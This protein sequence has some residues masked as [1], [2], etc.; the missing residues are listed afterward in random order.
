MN[1]ALT[2]SHVNEVLNKLYTFVTQEKN[3][4]PSILSQECGADS[5]KK[6]C[7]AISVLFNSFKRLLMKLME[8]PEALWM[9]REWRILELR[10]I[11]DDILN[12]RIPRTW[13]L[14]SKFCQR[15][16]K[17]FS[18]LLLLLQG[19][20]H[21]YSSGLILDILQEAYFCIYW[22]I[23]ATFLKHLIETTPRRFP[24]SSSTRYGFARRGICTNARNDAWWYRVESRIW[25]IFDSEPCGSRYT[26]LI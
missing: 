8:L 9:Q 5:F 26:S 13:Q 7:R 6:K 4:Y 20:L 10:N 12:D 14:L 24:S 25:D 18:G 2:I 19:G 17:T 1:T 23:L 22:K 21:F 16:P 15:G 3:A 11:I